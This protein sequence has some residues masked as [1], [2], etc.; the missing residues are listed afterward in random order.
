MGKGRGDVQGE[1]EGLTG[2]PI[3]EDPAEPE[4]AEEEPAA[5][6]EEEPAAVIEEEPAPGGDGPADAPGEPDP[7]GATLDSLERGISLLIERHAELGRRH[8][9]A[10]A[11]SREAAQRLERLTADGVDPERLDR[12][13]RELEAANARLQA[14]AKFLEERIQGFLQRVRYVVEA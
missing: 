8:R 5:V 4:P 12:R 2:A 6:I 1:F 14:H 13:I 3:G 7:L 11:E 9:T 10:V